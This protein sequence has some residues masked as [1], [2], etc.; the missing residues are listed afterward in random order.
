LN[1]LYVEVKNPL[2][3]PISTISKKESSLDA[4]AHVDVLFKKGLKK[5]IPGKWI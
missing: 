5:K 4:N 2:K 1:A 3:K